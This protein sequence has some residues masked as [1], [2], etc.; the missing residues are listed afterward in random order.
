MSNRV[1]APKGGRVHWLILNLSNQFK[2]SFICSYH[3]NKHNYS[4][5]RYIGHSKRLFDLFVI[6]R[7][8]KRCFKLV[9]TNFIS[10]IYIA[11]T[12]RTSKECAMYMHAIF[13]DSSNN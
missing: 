11:R 1:G 6:V 8:S 4:F 2:S 9:Y 7:T 10:S 3:Y 13:E 5:Y 12:F